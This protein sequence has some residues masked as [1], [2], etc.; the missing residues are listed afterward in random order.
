MYASLET[1]VTRYI[2]QQLKLL[3]GLGNLLRAQ[4]FYEHCC[5]IIIVREQCPFAAYTAKIKLLF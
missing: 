1:G 4:I 2:L 3:Q 5:S